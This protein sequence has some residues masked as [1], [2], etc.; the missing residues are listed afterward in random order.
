[1]P[2]LDGIIF[3]RILYCSIKISFEHKNLKLKHYHMQIS[4]NKKAVTS[5]TVIDTMLYRSLVLIIGETVPSY[6]RTYIQIQFI[7][8]SIIVRIIYF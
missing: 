6:T 7:L 1:M 8:K 3:K 2:S 5:A 4:P